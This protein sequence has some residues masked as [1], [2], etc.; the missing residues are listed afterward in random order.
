[1]R[2]FVQEYTQNWKLEVLFNFDLNLTDSWCGV[3]PV[4]VFGTG[5]PSGVQEPKVK[6]A[7][8]AADLD[9]VTPYNE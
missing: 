8:A 2:G 6:A 5:L 1:M 7:S 3:S 4:S 9:S